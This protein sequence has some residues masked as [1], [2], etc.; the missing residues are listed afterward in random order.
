M[1]E[2]LFAFLELGLEIFFEAVFEFA[3][4]VSAD[5]L[6]QSACEPAL[7]TINTRPLES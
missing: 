6:C 2:L 4:L 3:A 7:E 1:L 5:C